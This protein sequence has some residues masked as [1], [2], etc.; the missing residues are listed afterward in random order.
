M[1]AKSFSLKTVFFSTKKMN[2]VVFAT[3]NEK[4]SNIAI[5][6]KITSTTAKNKSMFT[7]FFYIPPH[8]I[9]QIKPPRSIDNNTVLQNLPVE[10]FLSLFHS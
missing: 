3:I 10:N 8:I 4:T 7:L 5:I 6:N 2:S 1:F 9:P